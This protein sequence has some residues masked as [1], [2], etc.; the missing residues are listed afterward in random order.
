MSSL[1][2]CTKCGGEKPL[3]EFKPRKDNPSG[4]RT[5]CKRCDYDARIDW[6]SRTIEVR[7]AKQVVYDATAYRN[8]RDVI[9]E[10][11]R[12]YSR[13]HKDQHAARTREWNSRN[14]DKLAAANLRNRD[15]QYEWRRTHPDVYAAHGAKRKAA[16][17]NATP[18]WIDQNHF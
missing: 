3:T 6:Y 16:Q 12:N 1:K 17:L 9:L 8:H 13:S 4:Y 5:T 14:P 7:R 18:P 2:V 15:R 10:R 11:S